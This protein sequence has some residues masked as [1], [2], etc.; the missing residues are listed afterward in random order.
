MTF[1]A[2]VIILTELMM[3][4]MT[5]HVVHYSGF[6]KEQKLWYLLTFG[7]VM[8]CAGAEFAVHC[9]VYNPAFAVPLTVLTVLQFSLAPMLGVFFTGALGLHRQ[10]KLASLFFSLNLLVE[11]VAA[12]FKWI[13]SFDQTG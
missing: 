1:Y 13:F 4:A 3:V 9:G 12:P 11:I 6:T 2:N 10:A 5:L 8:L 7:S